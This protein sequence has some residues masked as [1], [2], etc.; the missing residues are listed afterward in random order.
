MSGLVVVLFVLVQTEAEQPP[1]IGLDF[2]ARLPLGANR[3]NSRPRLRL[4]VG[5]LPH[6][7]C[8]IGSRRPSPRA[9][10]F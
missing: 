4:P 7:I 3:Y 2:D 8:G 10:G 6:E 1:N 9:L 5:P